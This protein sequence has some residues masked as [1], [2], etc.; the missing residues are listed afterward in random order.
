MCYSYQI[1]FWLPSKSCL[2]P[3]KISFPIPGVDLKVSQYFKT[4]Y[5]RIFLLLIMSMITTI[6]FSQTYITNVSVVDV[7]N[8]T[9]LPSQTVVFKDNKIDA[10]GSSRKIKVPQNAKIID[11]S[12]KYLVPGLV[13]AH[14]HFFQSGG[15]YTR[16][17]VINL[18]KYVPYEKEIKWVHQNMEDQLRR[19]V[20]SGITTVIDVGS[21]INF[22]KQ[23]DSFANKPYAP[24]IYMTGPLITSYEP[25]TYKGLKDDE[26][27]YL[28]STAEQAKEMVQ[29]QLPYKPDLIKIWYIVQGT[30]PEGAAKKFLPVVKTVVEEAHKNNLKVAVH[31][32]ERL[33]A[34]LAVENGADFLVHDVDDEIL[35]DDF[36]AL[37]KKHQTILCPTLVVGADYYKTF[38]QEP[39]ITKLDL[40]RANP[41]IIGSLFDLKQLDDTTMVNQYKGLGKFMLHKQATSD[42]IQRINLLKMV[43][44][45]IT[46]AS[47]TDAGNIGTPH[48]SSYFHELNAMKE[49]G[50]SN[51][52]ILTASTINGAKVLGKENEFGTIAKG[53]LADMILL[54]GNPVEDLEHLQKI[55]IVINKGNIID[56]SKNVI[57]TPESLVQQQLNA[58]NARD[59]EAFLEPYA[60]DVELYDFPDKLDSK[61]KDNMRKSYSQMFEALPDLHCEITGRIVQGNVVIDHERVTGFGNKFFTA[62]A[63]YHIENGK[64][65][66]VYF[67][68]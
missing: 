61:G 63:I 10:V 5:M 48:A 19:Y 25:E 47:G 36:I 34:Q 6:T 28:V 39:G 67:V 43:R 26:P 30:D 50:L 9:I 49:S 17:D 51:W 55:S 60:D 23:R 32:T 24:A 35:S 52:E 22:L 27:F 40:D 42:S 31:A 29:K 41:T 58:Y 46:I 16:P 1:D 13:D 62:I 38:A 59:V 66:K 64:I 4:D 8:A 3:H 15:L 53:K 11:G 44:N 37:L 54:D 65:H 68:Q 57:S 14:V 2:I 56:P 21:T 7:V 20:A 18:K 12:G 33:T 45:G